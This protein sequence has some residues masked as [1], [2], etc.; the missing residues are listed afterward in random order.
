MSE[1]MASGRVG[2]SGG[3]R[4]GAVRYRVDAAPK[5]VAHCHC[6]SCRRACGA[7]LVTWAGYP[8]DAF[9]WTGAEP[10]RYA[11]SP[12]VSRS[13]CAACGTPLTYQAERWADEVHVLAATLDDPAALSPRAHVHWR[14]HLPWIELADGLPRFATTS[15]EEKGAGEDRA[16]GQEACG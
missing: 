8:R 1:S 14:E 6:E 4:C 12:G 11:S 2:R 16:G 7:P 13:F 5:W 9:A 15:D 10:R 3:C